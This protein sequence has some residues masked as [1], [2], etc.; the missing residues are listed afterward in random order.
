MATRK[1]IGMEVVAAFA[2][3]VAAAPAGVVMTVT[4][5]RTKSL[6]TLG[7]M[8]SSPPDERDSMVTLR[9]TTKPF[10]ARPRT[11][12]AISSGFLFVEPASMNPITGSEDCARTGHTQ[13]VAAPPRNA[14]NSRRLIRSPRRRSREER[15]HRETQ[16]PRG[17]MINNE[18]KLAGL[19]N[20]QVRRFCALKD[21]TGIDA[22][23]MIRIWN[24]GPVAHQPADFSSLTRRISRRDRPVC[25]MLDN[26]NA[27]GG[28]IGVR[29]DEKGVGVIAL[30]RCESKIDLRAGSGFERLDLQSKGAGSRVYA[31][32]SCTRSG[33]IP[34]IGEYG[35][36]FRGGH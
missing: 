21:T 14:M 2:A 24:A 9:S 12:A 30:E 27:S 20:R 8:R 33:R 11:N 15:R 31:S 29:A 10:S 3:I 6:T 35:Y 17:L 32:R 34:W 26:L 22:K 5:R 1:A 28:E 19:R 16:H 4:L 7:N 13:V 25:C 23:H 18:F 36:S